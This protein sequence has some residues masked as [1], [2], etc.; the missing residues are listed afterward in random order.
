MT[1]V[2]TS[3][4][5]RKLRP[6]D[7]PVTSRSIALFRLGEMCHNKCPMCSNSGRPEAFFTPTEELV[8]RVGF[9]A[10]QSMPRV[11]LTGGEPTIHPG[12]WDV[13][14]ALGER[15]IR[16]D[17]NTHARPLSDPDFAARARRL[18]LGRAIV[19]LHSHE[20]EA[21]TTI[22]GMSERG[23]QETVDGLRNLLAEG[24]WVMVN[25][26]LTTLNLDHLDD[27]LRW[28]AEHVGTGYVV[29]MV[30]PYTGG[31]GG[32]WEGIQLTYDQVRDRVRALPPLARELGLPLVFESFPNCVLG[33]RKARNVSRSGFGETHYLDDV[34]GD[35]LYPIDHI[36]ASLHV[37]P[38]ACRSCSAI[39]RCGGISERYARRVGVH[40]LTPFR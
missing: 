39:Q 30:F 13:V 8:R 4:L 20:V 22:S 16:W 2:S 12:F 24:V 14:E 32:D 21:S 25:C 3:R 34:T 40:E 37:Y 23:H 35:R 29:K 28:L 18:G 38:E 9:L 1:T 5:L 10:S 33:E 36:E 15:R 17:I 26:V 6:A 19:S 31:K 7:K 27:Y 11:V